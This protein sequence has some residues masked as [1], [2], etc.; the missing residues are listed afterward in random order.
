MTV[1]GFVTIHFF[2]DVFA[3][4][5][6]M[7]PRTFEAF[8]HGGG[9]PV[10]EVV[11]Q[12]LPQVVME[13]LVVLVN[14]VPV[15]TPTMKRVYV[16]DVVDVA[17][18]P[19]EVVSI[20]LAIIAV[21]SAV[22]SAYLV[23]NV[24]VP[25]LRDGRS[26]QEQRYG[27]SRYSNDAFAGD[28]KGVVFGYEPAYGGKVI[29]RI[30]G[31]SPD[32]SGNERMKILIDLGHG[33]YAEIGGLNADTDQADAASLP[34]LQINEQPAS[35]FPGCTASVR[36]GTL[37]Q[38]PIRGFDDIETLLPVGV[39]GFALRNTSGADRTSGT[40]SGEAVTRV[41][42]A[43]VNAITLRVI[44]ETGLYSIA[45]NQVEPA[46]VRYRSR[47]RSAPGGVPT[48]SYSAWA[49]WTVRQ[50]DQSPFW[51]S[52]RIEIGAGVGG[53]QRVEVQLERITKEPT[54]ATTVDAMTWDSVV[55]IVD[56]EQNY[57]NSAL[58][59]VEI[60][61]GENISSVPRI[62]V[63]VK[64]YAAHRIWDGASAP[65]SPVFTTGW[66]ENPADISLTVAT[67]TRFGAG[68]QFQDKD[69]NFPALLAWR[70]HCAETISRPAG[71]TRARY[72]C[73]GQMGEKKNAIDWLNSIAAAGKARVIPF[74][75]ALSWVVEKPQ[76]QPVEIFNDGTIAR[77]EKGVA[78]FRWR[79]EY[80]TAG[81]QRKNQMIV[82]FKNKA[83]G[84]RTETITYP[85]V[86]ELWLG[87][88][89]AESPNSD[90]KSLD[91]CNDLDEAAAFAVVEMNKARALT[92]TVR[93]TPTTP[94]PAIRPGERFDLATR[95]MGYGHASGRVRAGSTTTAVVL[96]QAVTFEEGR[97]YR[98]KVVQ[99]DASVEVRTITSPTGDYPRGTAIMLE[100]AL[101]QAPVEDADYVVENAAENRIAKPYTLT[102]L[103][104]ADTKEKLWE[105]EGIEYDANVY[106]TTPGVVVVPSYS[107]L[108]TPQTP[109]GPVTGLRAF[110]R[111]DPATNRAR[112]ELSWNQLPVDA[113]N[114]S[115]FR[116]YRR[117][118][119]TTTWQLIPTANVARRTAVIDLTSLDRG[120]DF[121]VVAVSVG[122]AFLSPNDPRH[123]TATLVLG[124]SDDPPPAPTT[125]TITNVAGNGYDLSWTAVEGAVGYV[126]YSG[127]YPASGLYSDIVDA[128]VVARVEANFLLGLRLPVFTPT[129]HPICFYVRSVGRNGRMSLGVLA[130]PPTAPTG[131]ESH[132]TIDN[133]NAPAG[134]AVKSTHELNLTGTGTATNLATVSGAITPSNV[135]LDGVWES[136]DL[137]TGAL[138]LTQLALHLR[139]KNFAE[140]PD[141]IDVPFLVPSIEADQWGVTGLGPPRVVG[142]LFPPYPDDRHQF[143]VEIAIK[144]GGSYGP[145]TRVT[146]FALFQAT[147]RYFK[148]RITM[149]RGA[150]PYRPGV[151]RL[152]VVSFA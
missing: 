118:T 110:E 73:N 91:W 35:N 69:I 100:S 14:G 129:D 30:P 85:R 12:V 79:R 76:A 68:T 125:V 51:S 26:P 32:G 27:F 34:T 39:N 92:R 101:T 105:I 141:L 81:L 55:E 138:S 102:R 74:G 107:G 115:I 4:G 66:S 124:L 89:S 150:Y 142:M 38:R 132:V 97:V 8:T 48:G 86:G 61:A 119:G 13:R 88:P 46:T 98:L 137:D 72:T 135:A 87:G 42:S 152:D 140:D 23:S 20:V 116:I 151:A 71:G 57:P 103:A 56:A 111:I 77:D 133:A 99:A 95:L 121:C 108:V 64:G 84:G 37:N 2:D 22:A 114:T 41:T 106:S 24:K 17:P 126:V 15:A 109:P 33:P 112:A 149:R 49:T 5:A 139:T 70:T 28:V 47:W 25:G 9:V 19:G 104:S 94:F 75:N 10:S 148:V 128:F 1:P 43:S 147:L 50:G 120:Y 45:E 31:E 122:G 62:S 143:V 3:R 18:R 127:S 21:A 52:P 65:S 145:W 7:P 44:F 60:T 93:F 146:P 83:T 80:A 59:A 82:Q 144:I 11:P 117:P 29:A 123:P 78:K 136:A 130:A 36:M 16:G 63:G 113:A 134:M 6:G 53:A 54:D 90:Q 67:N 96:D 58:L 40:A 131:G